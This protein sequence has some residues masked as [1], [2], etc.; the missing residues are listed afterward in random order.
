VSDQSDIGTEY[1]DLGLLIDADQLTLYSLEYMETAIPGWVAQPANPETIMMEA[2]AQMASEVLAQ[3]ASVPDEAM[4]YLGTSIYGF[5]MLDGAPSRGNATVTFAQ[6]TPAM[7]IY[8]GT[9][10]SVPH[11]SGTTFLFE[12][13]RDLVAPDG[14]G[15]LTCT[16]IASEYGSAQNGCFGIGEFQ[17]E[18]D[19]VQSIVANTTLGGA[20]A[21]ESTDYLARFSTYL[22]ILTARPILPIDFARRAQLNPG[23]ERAVA[24]DLY[25]PGSAEG[26]Y[27]SPRGATAQTNVERCVTVVV[28]GPDGAAP[29]SVLMQDVWADLDANRE[30]NFLVY[31]IPPGQNGVYTGIDVRATV[32]PYPGV[33]PADAQAQAADQIAQWL[34]AST[35]GVVPGTATAA[36]WAVDDKVRIYEAV[37]WINRATVIHYVVSVEMK[38]STDSTWASADI[39]LGGAVPMPKVGA[40]PVITVA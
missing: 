16:L 6:N 31:V 23:V 13:D 32:H 25:Q 4:A 39:Q 14:G 24:L 9:E 38:K 8:Q 7:T 28:T 33:D 27:G 3:A 17:E 2:N 40:A 29:D 21:E 12:T 11:P 18:H 35:W 19:G 30:V 1:I 22:S 26:G 37:E 5:P 15:T 10:V 20:D 34:G 36:E